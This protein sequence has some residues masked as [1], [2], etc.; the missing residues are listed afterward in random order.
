MQQSES[1]NFLRGAYAEGEGTQMQQNIA[2]LVRGSG[3]YGGPLEYSS[4]S[5]PG[6]LAQAEQT[7]EE[8]DPNAQATEYL[9]RKKL[10]RPGALGSSN[11]PYWMRYA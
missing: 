9:R 11:V 5:G 10:G 1:K 4:Y 8:F 6:S 3:T 7:R 2:G